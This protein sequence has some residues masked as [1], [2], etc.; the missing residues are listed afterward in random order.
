[1]EISMAINED[2]LKRW[3]TAPSETEETKCQNAV[4]LITNAIKER[5]GSDVTVFLQGSYK[6]R[7]N[8][9]QDSDVDIVV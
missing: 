6:N 7:T 1:M 5:F 8:V 4:R 2:Q 9:R 3:A